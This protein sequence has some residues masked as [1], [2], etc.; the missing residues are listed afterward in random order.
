VDTPEA[1]P[2]LPFEDVTERKE[3]E[4]QLREQAA[5]LE[6]AP[7][8]VRDLDN[9]IV[10]WTHGAQHLYGFS[11]AEALGR[12]SHDL[13][14]T[15][16]PD[17]QERMDEA[18]RRAGR[19]EGELVHRTR[20]GE[21]RVV[22]SQQIVYRNAGGRPARILEVNADLTEVHQAEQARRQAEQRFSLLARSVRD[23][24]I[25]CWT[26]KVASHTGTRGPRGSKATRKPKCWASTS[27]CFTRPTNWPPA[28][29]NA[30]CN[31]RP[32][33]AVR[34]R[35]TGESAKAASASGATSS[36]C[37][38]GMRKAN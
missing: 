25:S 30:S 28:D 6:L 20:S 15:H 16:F 23:Y 1:A 29:P 9:R 21:W 34:T 4:G 2:T 3:A 18:L 10:L 37:R 24:A 8:L 36:S 5:L 22:A 31:K 14:Q 33:R 32:P 13:L 17:S 11:K 7:V 38:Y 27:R 35:K 12:V 19:W 26:P